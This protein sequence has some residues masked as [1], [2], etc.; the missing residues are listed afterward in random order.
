MSFPSYT[1]QEKS[2]CIVLVSSE[3]DPAFN[4]HLARKANVQENASG[5]N[6]A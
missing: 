4:V 1:V 2:P 3:L 5:T 6:K